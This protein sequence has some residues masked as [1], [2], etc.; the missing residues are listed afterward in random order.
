VDQTLYTILLQDAHLLLGAESEQADQ[1]R[2]LADN[3]SDEDLRRILAEHGQQTQTQIQRLEEILSAA[4]E[5]P[6]GEVPGAIEGLI[7]DAQMMIDQEL[8]DVSDI[9]IAGALRKAEHYEIGCYETAIA[10][11]EQLGLE[12]V[13]RPLRESLAEEQQA[14][15]RLAQTALKLIQARVPLETE[16]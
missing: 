6:E 1:L 4:G 3:V 9:A 16:A 7:D 8:G 13:V 10:I 2:A 14:E 12:D 5:S 15:Q 11:A